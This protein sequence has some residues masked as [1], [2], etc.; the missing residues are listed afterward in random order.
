[1]WWQG[2]AKKA[3]NRSVTAGFFPAFRIEHYHRR[4]SLTRLQPPH[5][6]WKN[7]QTL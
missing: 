4:H 7:R 3:P 1:L 2:G 5:A 6:P